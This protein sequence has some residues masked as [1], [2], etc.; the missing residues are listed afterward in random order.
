MNENTLKYWQYSILAFGIIALFAFSANTVMS[1]D[2]VVASI[3]K[4][5]TNPD[6]YS[7]GTSVQWHGTLD[8]YLTKADTGERTQVI[9]GEPNLITDLGAN[10]LRGYLNGSITSSASIANLS[11]S[12]DAGAASDA[13]TELPSEIATNGLDRATAA[14][15]VVNNGTT[16]FNVTH[17]WTAT[18]TQSCQ[19]I[20]THWVST[21]SSDGNLFSALKFTQ[22]NLLVNDQLE[23]V[24][25]VEIS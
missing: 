1:N 20:G 17:T 21:D 25:S 24:Y 13:W 5:I 9:F 12:N 3:D 15:G 2:L 8:M 6:T 11:L 16:K 4:Q 22:Q 10:R 7:S 19:L 14:G 23:A 18:D